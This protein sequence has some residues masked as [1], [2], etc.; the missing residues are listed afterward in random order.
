MNLL[1]SSRA[2]PARHARVVAATPPVN[3]ARSCSPFAL[4]PSF[5][6]LAFCQT[7]PY[8]EKYCLFR[9][10]KISFHVAPQ[11]FINTH[12]TMK[13]LYPVAEWFIFDGTFTLASRCLC[14]IFHL[15]LSEYKYRTSRLVTSCL[16]YFNFFQTS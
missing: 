14:P 15:T 8:L 13:V 7:D 2:S 12:H 3:S 10:H 5:C 9:D 11:A 1:Q 6:G 4:A 16:S